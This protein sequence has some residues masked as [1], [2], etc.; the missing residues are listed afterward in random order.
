MKK[1][2]AL[3]MALMTAVSLC[4]FAGA[5]AADVS[6]LKIAS[7]AGAPGLALAALAVESPDQYTFVA[8]DTI[9]AE[10]ASGTS[11]FIIAPL[12]AGAKLYKAGK[13]TYR[14][15]AVVSWGNLFFASRRA[16][17]KPEDMNGAAV[18]L[19]GENTIN[20]AVA[21]YALE[22]N[23]IVPASVEYLA[24]ASNTQQ[25]LLSDAEAIVLTAEPALTAAGMKA[26]DITGYALN[27]LYKS[28]TGQD[29]YPQAGLFV[30]A[31]LIGEA[32]AVA[33]EYIRMVEASC[34]LCAE[35]PAA[36]AEAT[37]ALELLPNVKVA[38]A[39][40]PNCAIRFVPA[41]EAKEQIENTAAIDL[42]QF[43]GAVPADDFYY[44]AE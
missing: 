40:I 19:F 23:G 15:A 6:A 13:S 42:S 39:A 1:S 30:R 18:T 20:A 37:V 33:D 44:G 38:L 34:A 29:G 35:D 28:A 24:A 9:T 25:L 36:A 26:D 16:G 2:I 10:F 4:V 12:N 14:L 11:D 8:A 5:E 31:G 32:P 3:L 7:P 41:K 17:F 22:K 21:L 43:G 27:D